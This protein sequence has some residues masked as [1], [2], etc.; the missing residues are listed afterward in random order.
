VVV[1]L[2][3]PWLPDDGHAEHVTRTGTVAR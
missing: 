1:P 3:A 2:E